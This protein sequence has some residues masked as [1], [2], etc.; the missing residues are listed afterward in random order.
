MVVMNR[1]TVRFY[2]KNQT[3]GYFVAP[4]RAIGAAVPSAGRGRTRAA[5]SIGARTV[6]NGS[7]ERPAG[8]DPRGMRCLSFR[9]T[10]GVTFSKLL[11]R[12]LVAWNGSAPKG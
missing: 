11:R 4:V 8:A 10:T 3:T 1:T 9:T 7:V 12:V 5:G 6:P 2:I